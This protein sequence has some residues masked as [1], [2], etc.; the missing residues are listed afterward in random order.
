MIIIAQED[1]KL[2]YKKNAIRSV[3]TEKQRRVI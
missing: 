2:L 3:F 1:Y